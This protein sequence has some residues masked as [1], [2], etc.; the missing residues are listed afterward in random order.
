MLIKDKQA[1]H[2]SHVTNHK[3]LW[4]ETQ[5]AAAGKPRA[6]T[7]PKGP[8][9]CYYQYKDLV[10]NSFSLPPSPPGCIL[11]TKRRGG[12]DRRRGNEELRICVV[13]PLGV[14]MWVPTPSTSLGKQGSFSPSST[15]IALCL[16]QTEQR[17][18]TLDPGHHTLNWWL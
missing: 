4:S 9:L 11:R 10:N 17:A 18:L 1:A 2:R 5:L 14:S 16:S 15:R 7:H 13:H 12:Q 8:G 6:H 3:Y